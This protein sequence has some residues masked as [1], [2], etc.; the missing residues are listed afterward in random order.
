MGCHACKVELKLEGTF[1][2]ELNELGRGFLTN[3][4]IG[5]T[6]KASQVGDRL[7]IACWNK[8]GHRF[9]SSVMVPSTR[10]SGPPV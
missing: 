9:F 2:G 10:P 7:I 4:R 6:D 1:K 8:A 5:Q 3:Q